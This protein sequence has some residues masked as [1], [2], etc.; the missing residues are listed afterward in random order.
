MLFIL[1]LDLYI[2]VAVLG[3]QAEPIGFTQIVLSFNINTNWES[4]VPC[5]MRVPSVLSVLG[6]WLTS[7]L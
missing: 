4:L 7:R 5:F 3:R 2:L 6:L 1:I